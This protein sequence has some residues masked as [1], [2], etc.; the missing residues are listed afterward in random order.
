MTEIA[1]RPT[2]LKWYKVV[3]AHATDAESPNK[4]Y[5]HVMPIRTGVL[6]KVGDW[7]LGSLSTAVTFVPD[8]GLADFGLVE[9]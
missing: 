1:E 9:E 3:R 6:V 4:N 2:K 8:V 7:S 5:T